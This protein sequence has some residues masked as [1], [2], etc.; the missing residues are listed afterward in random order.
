MDSYFEEENSAVFTR[1]QPTTARYAETETRSVDGHSQSSGE[2]TSGVSRPSSIKESPTYPPTRQSTQSSISSSSYPSH[3]SDP[4][5]DY[6]VQSNAYPPQ[7]GQSFGAQNYPP[8]KPNNFG[9]QNYS[10]GSPSPS[11]N[12]NK[13]TPEL[14]HNLSNYRATRSTS[15]TNNISTLGSPTASVAHLPQGNTLEQYRINA[16]KSNDPSIQ[17][18]F[19]KYLIET[20]TNLDASDK[21]TEKTKKALM[22]EA[23]K[24]IKR[25]ATQGMGIGRPAYPEAQFYLANCYGTA[26][27]GLAVDH[28]KAFNLYVQA[29]KQNHPAATYRAAVCYEVGAGTKRDYSRAVQ[30]FRKAAILGETAAMYKLGM[31]LLKGLLNQNQ[32]PREAIT[33]LK[34]AASNADTENPHAL[35]EL[36]LCYEKE[37]IPSIIPDESYSRELYT[38]AAQLGYAPSQFKLG[39][40]YEYGTCTCP[41]DPRRSIAWYTRAAEQGDPEAELALSGWYLTGADGILKQSDTEAYLWARKAADKGLA[42]AEY[43]VGYYSEVGIGVRQDLNEAKKWYMRAAAQGNKR[44]MQRLSELKKFGASGGQKQKISRD[45]QGSDGCVIC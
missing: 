6:G 24:W 43:A 27:M 10:H 11:L 36:A 13:S 1:K 16:K 20:A 38:Q 8:Q 30:F 15:S 29:S 22:A 4:R 39:S 12:V 33:W 25:L 32:N 35:H 41:V 31:T 37:G 17:F 42:K 40:C 44:A 23:L 9:V 28:E 3:G 26:T 19:A 45:K 21:T 5:P 18:D 14:P 7:A 34:R 2:G